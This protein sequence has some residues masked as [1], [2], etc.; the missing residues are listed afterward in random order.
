MLPSCSDDAV[1]PGSKKT[2]QVG[3]QAMT[4]GTTEHL[5]D[6]WGRSG[7]DVLAVGDNGTILHYDGNAWAQMN[8]GTTQNLNGVSGNSFRTVVTGDGGI[9]LFQ[10]ADIWQEQPVYITENIGAV[11]YCENMIYAVG[12]GPPGTILIN[13]EASPIFWSAIETGATEG[14]VNLIGF[15]DYF[16]LVIAVGKK[17]TAYWGTGYNWFAMD[18]AT[19]EDLVAVF[20]ESPSNVYAVSSNGTIFQNNKRFVQGGPELTWREVA[21]LTGE[22]L[23][24]MSM[25]SH[26]DIFIVG[27]NGRVV[28]FNRCKVTEMTTGS[29]AALRAVWCGE[30]DVLAV[31]DN[32][33][34]L[35]YSDQP[36]ESACPVNVNISVSGGTTPTISWSP[37]C[38]ITKLA[39]EDQKGNVQWF[40]ACDGNLIRP[41]V[42]YGIVPECAVEFCPM[43]YAMTVGEWYRV[44]LIRRDWD[45]EY[46]IGAWNIVPQDSRSARVMKTTPL[47]S[48]TLR[49][50]AAQAS[51]GY[52]FEKRIFYQQLRQTIPGTEIYAFAGVAEVRDWGHGIPDPAVREEELNIRPVIV[53]RFVINPETGLAEVIT[54]TNIRAAG[55]VASPVVWDLIAVDA[56]DND[57]RVLK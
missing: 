12:G 30:T 29:S 39:I 25:R 31:G 47:G 5:N 10:Y 32:G 44:S 4:S 35:R 7:D 1:S 9:V 37:S 18:T 52:I 3:W 13:D 16:R 27:E 55:S 54:Y 21:E 48:K 28:H 22:P 14:F 41:E 8:S 56:N 19:S 26:N 49:Y 11:W 15:S 42:E 51:S 23:H 20:G 36:A 33:T 40:I 57:R 45:H 43:A 50:P 2:G 6:V 38:A 46:V 34:I 17:G 24:D 53:E